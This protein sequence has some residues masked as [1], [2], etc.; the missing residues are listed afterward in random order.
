MSNTLL[1]S[2]A[3]RLS[4]HPENIATE[5]L[6]HILVTH[7]SAGDALLRLLSHSGLPKLEALTFRTQAYGLEGSIPDLVGIASDGGEVLM[8]EAKFW[9]HLT[10][11]QPNTYLARLIS[12]RPSVL[13][14]VCPEARLTGLWGAL[15]E[16]AREAGYQMKI[17]KKSNALMFSSV[18]ATRHIGIVSW[19]AILDFLIADAVSQ[20]DRHYESD[21]DQLQ[22]LCDRMDSE[23]F[24]PIRSG[25]LS[26]EI[27]RRVSQ[28]AHLVDDAVT[29]L[30]QEDSS[31][32]TKGLTTGGVHSAYGRYFYYGDSIGAFLH[33]SPI[34]WSSTGASP[35]WLQMKMKDSP[36]WRNHP[37]I[38]E[39]MQQ[40][41][42]DSRFRLAESD[43]APALAIMLP[44]GV[45]K[46]DVAAKIVEQVRHALKVTVESLNS[47]TP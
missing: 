1:A 29:L 24:L 14:F 45:E 22:G 41:T 46:N 19:R 21:V 5:A 6:L 31:V 8:L 43:G 20:G 34:L 25:E 2:L 33:F 12:T 26:Q 11:N 30:V 13:L 36:K 40:H 35:I 39:A 42:I 7:H 47:W 3:L 15:K 37:A 17:E 4:S 23:A 18:D 38:L 44:C 10:E 16:R 27:G 32:S 28:F 9:A